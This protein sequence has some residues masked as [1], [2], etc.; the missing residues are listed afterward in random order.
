MNKSTMSLPL[1]SSQEGALTKQVLRRTLL[2]TIRSSCFWVHPRSLPGMLKEL[3]D[4]NKFTPARFDD[5]S[6]NFVLEK[7]VAQILERYR[8]FVLTGEATISRARG[9]LLF[10]SMSPRPLVL[11]HIGIVPTSLSLSSLSS[12]VSLNATIAVRSRLS[13][14]LSFSSIFFRSG[15][16]PFSSSS[17][18]LYSSS[19]SPWRSPSLV[20]LLSLSSLYPISSLVS[21][22]SYYSYFSHLSSPFFL[23]HIYIYTYIHIYIYTYIHIYIYTYIHIYIYT[24]IHIYIYTYIHIYIYTYICF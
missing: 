21:F 20:Y 15:L 16:S 12:L 7:K 17:L 1:G 4:F 22:K 2:N 3:I 5:E 19:P 18:S 6:V 8:N 13:L 24:Y 11:S 14:T 23:I 9:M 10:V